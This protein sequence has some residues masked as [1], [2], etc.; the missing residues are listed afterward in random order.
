MLVNGYSGLLPAGYAA[1]IRACQGFPDARAHAYLKRLGVKYVVLRSPGYEVG[2]WGSLLGRLA[3]SRAL[4]PPVQE[5]ADALV[6][7]VR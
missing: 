4:W 2:E 7:E 5:F 1:T 6:V 3:A